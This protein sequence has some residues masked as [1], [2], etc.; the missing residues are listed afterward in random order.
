M[1]KTKHYN[2]KTKELGDGI[3]EAMITTESVDRDGDIVRADGAQ[4]DNYF[5]NPVVLFGHNY[6][7]PSAVIGKATG[8]EVIPGKGVRAEF[9]FAS[10]V[11]NDAALIERLWKGGYLSAVSIGF[12]VD[13]FE[14]LDE[15]EPYGGWDIKAW[16]LLEFSVV[17]IPANQD[18]LRLGLK[19]LDAATKGAS[20]TDAPQDTEPETLEPLILVEVDDDCQKDLS[21]DD[22]DEL[23]DNATE[24]NK[25]EK[26][27]P[28]PNTNDPTNDESEA[29]NIATLVNSVKSLINTFM[30]VTN[31]E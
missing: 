11:S 3:Y 27:T 9:Q 24:H 1:K 10:D 31:N 4:L 6:R 14:P 22:T 13:E 26:D 17:P 28:T 30:E 15:K 20:Y 25:H 18:A 23:S 2:V 19:A 7:E 8:L 21:I 29:A 12:M 5:N 16:E